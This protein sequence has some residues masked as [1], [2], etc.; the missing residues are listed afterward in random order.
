MES[1]CLLDLKHK[2]NFL[3]STYVIIPAQS[4]LCLLLAHILLKEHL[5]KQTTDVEK[6]NVVLES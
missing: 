4:K 5:K 1:S 6:G 2:Y 3:K